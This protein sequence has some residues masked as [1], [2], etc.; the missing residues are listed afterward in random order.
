MKLIICSLFLSL[1]VVTF[2]SAQKQA[3]VDNGQFITVAQ[4]TGANH[5]THY[6]MT[7]NN[8]VA[9]DFTLYKEV[10]GGSWDVTRHLNLQPAAAYDDVNSFTGLTGRYVLYSAPHSDWASFPS[11]FDIAKLQASGAVVPATGS[12]AAPAPATPATTPAPATTTTTTTTPAQPA[13]PAPNSAQ[14]KD[15][16]PPPPPPAL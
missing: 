4:T 16:A 9:M 5:Q 7:N 8:T 15:S 14:N 6:T 3:Q 10:K 2:A 12:S 13:S 1:G 11:S